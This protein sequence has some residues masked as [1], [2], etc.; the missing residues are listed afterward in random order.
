[1]A[2]GTIAPVGMTMVG[3]TADSDPIPSHNMFATTVAINVD[4]ENGTKNTTKLP[5]QENLQEECAP[6]NVL[7]FGIDQDQSLNFPD[8]S[9]DLA[10]WENC[11]QFAADENTWNDF[12]DGGNIE[13]K[14]ALDSAFPNNSVDHLASAFED[15]SA[16]DGTSVYRNHD[17]ND[18]YL[19]DFE[20]PLDSMEL[21]F[22]ASVQLINRE[23]RP[24]M[25][26]DPKYHIQQLPHSIEN[27][28]AQGW[29]GSRTVAAGKSELIPRNEKRAHLTNPPRSIEVRRG[30]ANPGQPSGSRFHRN[31]RFVENGAYKPL[32]QAPK[33]WDIFQYTRLGELI[34][35]PFS[36]D[37]INRF[38]FTHPL[39]AGFHSLKESSLRLRVHRTPASSASRFPNG[40]TCRMSGCPMHNTI[41]Q[42]QL[43]VVLDEL[44][45]QHPDHDPFLNAGYVHLYCLERYCNF[46][47]IC[48][49]LN[50]SAKG[51]PCHYEEGRKNRFRLSTEEVR[52]VEDFVEAC[53]A[54][55]ARGSNDTP[56]VAQ[57]EHCPDQGTNGCPHYDQPSHPYKGTLCHQL[58]VTKL[59]FGG[60]G[61]IH[62]REAREE[63]AGYRGANIIRHLGDL[64]EEA[65]LRA[66]S[67]LHKNQNQL[68]ANPKTE[69]RYRTD[70][71]EEEE[72]DY[73]SH[74]GANRSQTHEPPAT[75]SAWCTKSNKEE[76]DDGHALS[77]NT[78]QSH[79]RPRYGVEFKTPT[80]NMGD[81]NAVTME[82]IVDLD[83][84]RDASMMDAPGLS[85]YTT[86]IPSCGPTRFQDG[87]VTS[88]IER[89]ASVKDLRPT[90][91]EEESERELELEILAAQKRRRQLEI[92]QALDDEREIRIRKSKLR[93]AKGKKRTRQ[94]GE[95]NY[96]AED[97][98]ELKGK[99]RKV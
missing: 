46:P 62:L 42:G 28:A 99:R 94:E 20:L 23:T 31:K 18:C 41:N 32:H 40:L 76:G 43:L 2:E 80:W 47:E 74:S 75:P 98:T 3:Y 38:L 39:H 22:L 89:P 34:P 37:E 49:R 13:E 45:V 19:G 88:R 21:D 67:R 96:D 16:C 15:P 5:S 63:K 91:L 57:L 14:S 86:V 29:D 24:T 85:P 9:G 71:L 44:S 78:V 35:R 73:C 53:C 12:D 97:E 25:S 77:Q 68:K 82:N 69:R 54:N 59:H 36:A 60:R 64:S 8:F 30:V 70:D 26:L 10:K 95:E 72:Q 81:L 50:V 11:L 1:M 92:E 61:K 84:D 17:F 87:L 52:V 93:E 66:Y 65:K 7:G 27:G 48:S 55:V 79:E 56:W 51:R 4:Q 6:G 90:I 33:S 83:D 58:I